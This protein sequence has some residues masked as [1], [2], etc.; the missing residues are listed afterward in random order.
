MQAGAGF[1]RESDAGSGAVSAVTGAPVLEQPE[2]KS[3]DEVDRKL[4]AEVHGLIE[5]SAI[6]ADKQNFQ[7]A[8]EHAKRAIVSERQLSKLR[9][10][11]SSESVNLDLT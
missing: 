9:E 5:Q 2:D 4:E 8:L 1:R 10:E 6:L 11:Q 7:Q 3:G